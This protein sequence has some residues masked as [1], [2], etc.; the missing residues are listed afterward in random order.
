M[1]NHN[2][3]LQSKNRVHISWDILYSACD[4]ILAKTERYD[5]KKSKLESLSLE[6]SWDLWVRRLIAKC[7]EAL[8]RILGMRCKY[9]RIFLY[10]KLNDI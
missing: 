8:C 5:K 7:I 3:A 6:T 9:F 1:Y 4:V 10:F 2:K